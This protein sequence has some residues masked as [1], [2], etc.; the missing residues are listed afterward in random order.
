M[1]C[2][3]RRLLCP[4]PRSKAAFLIPLTTPA[5]KRRPAQSPLFP[6][7]WAVSKQH[8]STRGC[9]APSSCSESKRH[10]AS[11]APDVVYASPLVQPRRR[12]RQKYKSDLP[13]DSGGV[14][15]ILSLRSYS[16]WGSLPSAVANVGGPGTARRFRDRKSEGEGARSAR[17]PR[18]LDL[19][20]PLNLQRV[21]TNCSAP[22]EA[23]CGSK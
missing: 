4:P 18:I 10:K 9:S 11:S 12:R 15:R 5:S 1:H 22:P 8:R 7:R 19:F 17:E 20:L 23:A 16:P 2:A 14:C 6:L 3:R 13:A 21:R